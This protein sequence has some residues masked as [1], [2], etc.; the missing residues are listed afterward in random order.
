MRLYVV[1]HGQTA[2]NAAF[3]AGGHKDIPLDDVGRAQ[4]KALGARFEGEHLNRVLSSDLQ[5]CV[6]TARPIALPHGIKIE[7]DP[8]L[9][10][11]SMGDYE[12]RLHEELV[13]ALER[14]AEREGTTFFEARPPNGESLMDVWVRLQP[15]VAELRRSE[16]RTVIVTHGGT[17]TLLLAGLLGMGPHM[18][19]AFRFSNTGV[20]E[21]RRRDDGSLVLVKHNDVS[22]LNGPVLSGDVEGVHS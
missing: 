2:W 16:G 11:R 5:R 7:T 8:R 9:R 13:K 15:V 19:R 14:I 3:L 10:E 6:E 22:H 1:R 21:I 4:A 17:A 18:A 20:S 12:G